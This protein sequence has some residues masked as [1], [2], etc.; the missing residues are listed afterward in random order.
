M[1]TNKRLQELSLAP[2]NFT[3][4]TTAALAKMLR[5]NSTLELLELTPKREIEEKHMMQI[6]EA[7]EENTSLKHFA[8][9][10][11]F[12]PISK[13][14]KQAFERMLEDNYRMQSFRIFS[15][16][17]SI[18]E[19]QMYLRLNKARRN[20][21]LNQKGGASKSD[22]LDAIYQVNDSLDCIFYFLS[23]NPFLCH[24]TK[25]LQN[26]F[27]VERR[28]NKRRRLN[29]DDTDKGSSENSSSVNS[30]LSS[31]ENENSSSPSQSV[32]H[33]ISTSNESDPVTTHNG[34]SFG[35]ASGNTE[36]THDAASAHVLLFMTVSFAA[37]SGQQVSTSESS[38]NAKGDGKAGSDDPAA[39]QQAQISSTSGGS[40]TGSD[41]G[42]NGAQQQQLPQ[43]AQLEA[44]LAS[45]FNGSQAPNMDMNPAALQALGAFQQQPSQAAPN[46]TQQQQQQ[47]L[48][49][50]QQ[51][52]QQQQNNPAASNAQPQ[53]PQQQQQQPQQNDANQMMA[54]NPTNALITM[55]L[56]LLLSSMFQQP[57]QSNPPSAVFTQDQRFGAGN[58]NASAPTQMQQAQQQAQGQG[59]GGQQQPQMQG[60]APG[61]QPQTHAAAAMP[62]QDPPPEHVGSS[63][64]NS[65][66]LFIARDR[67]CLSS[68]Q[69]LLR[70]QIELFEAVDEDV[71][72]TMPGRNKAI[73]LGQVGIRCRH[74]AMLPARYRGT[75]ATYYPAKL[76]RLYQAAQNMAQTHFTKHCRHI[77]QEL[78]NE[79]SALL[80]GSKSSAGAGKKY[81]SDGAR[82]LGA[83]E[84][85][86]ILRL[87]RSRAT[88]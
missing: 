52:L 43:Q 47:Q 51:F 8:L 72:S 23:V 46:I 9:D 50:F 4:V 85:D 34:K 33:Q 30:S 80:Q 84:I 57:T 67:D 11:D 28:G 86:E 75:G 44:F 3:I 16:F 83:Y 74:C 13:P 29:N 15:S 79:L 26:Q 56:P 32:D 42:P 37:A 7:L 63:P 62:G 58:S 59:G 31:S 20:F 61:S 66:P 39:N 55:A 81:W 76:D 27:R 17:Q 41:P 12:G 6:A 14:T 88:A 22:W 68:Y 38:D 48:Q 60:Q 64:R 45:L 73:V 78:V 71:K 36:T 82:M 87:D 49:Q 40:A 77:P 35:N 19:F 10:G 1:E 2:V 54:A 5:R 65:Y 21:L 18:P 25:E 53:Q 69:C 70:Q 24:T